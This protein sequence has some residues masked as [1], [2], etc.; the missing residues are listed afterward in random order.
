MSIPFQDSLNELGIPAESRTERDQ[1]RELERRFTRLQKHVSTLSTVVEAQT[2][3]IIPALVNLV[4]NSDFIMSDEVYNATAYTDDEDVLANWYRRTQSETDSWEENTGGAEA[5]NDSIRSSSHGSG[6]RTGAEWSTAEGTLHMSGGYRI[7]ARLFQKFA[8]AGN[9]FA[10]RCQI[11]K[12][13]IQ[14]TLDAG[15]DK[16]AST[17]ELISTAHGLAAQT[18][19]TLEIVTGNLPTCVP[20]LVEGTL[21]RI[22]SVTAD[23]FILE[24]ENS[25]LIDI[26][27]AS[28]DVGDYHVIPQLT[29]NLKLKISLWDNTDNEILKGDK[30][31][32][33][34]NKVGAHSGGT[35]TRDYILEAVMGDGRKFFSDTVVFT[36]G[37]NRATNTVATSSVN[38]TNYVNVS[39]DSVIGATRYN[40]YRKE[41]AGSWYLVGSSTNSST[42]LQDK[43]GTGGGVW[44][45]PTLDDENKEFPLAEAFYDD[46][47]ELISTFE[48]MNEASAGIRV[49]TTFTPNGNQFLQIEF[50]NEDY[51]DTTTAEIPTNMIRIDRVG[52]STTNGRWVP[53]SRDLTKTP[54]ITPDPPPSTGGSGDNPP[55]GRGENTCVEQSTPVLV[56]SDD[57]N[58][59]WRAAKDM[60][61]GDRLVSWDGSTLAPTTVY[62]VVKGISRKNYLIHSEGKVLSCSFSHRLITDLHDF[63]YGTPVRTEPTRTL[64]Y[65]DGEIQVQDMEVVEITDDTY[66]VVTFRLSSGRRNYIANGFFSHNAK[67]LEFNL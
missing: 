4:D 12:R 32:L 49:P 1:L 42:I 11:S 23:R 10:F 39:W 8:S 27:G 58:H 19:V 24:D 34:T 17:N 61:I 64:T 6:V 21:Y 46:V 50:V 18:L 36:D 16:D 51:T 33:T 14:L 43:G 29:P 40:L 38:A 56:W 62:R 26:D 65:T 53:S 9:Y 66:H 2:P 20:A 67:P 60:V 45:V 5:T 57:G 59:F 47:D 13:N 28:V 7:G 15:S 55:D 31:E 35:A 3:D 25:T 37:Q 63:E 48:Q 30:P 22:R 41:N 52:L 44:T 54:T